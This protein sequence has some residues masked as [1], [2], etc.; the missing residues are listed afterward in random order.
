MRSIL[1]RIADWAERDALEDIDRS[2]PLTCL[3]PERNLGFPHSWV[4]VCP[5]NRTPARRDN[6]S[7]S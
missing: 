1:D 3:L 7:T 2:A 4:R 5:P 6:R